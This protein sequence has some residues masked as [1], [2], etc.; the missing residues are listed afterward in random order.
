MVNH[1]LFN[2]GETII[3][4]GISDLLTPLNHNEFCNLFLRHAQGDWGIICEEDKPL[5]NEA[6]TSG[7]RI[8]SAYLFDGVKIW[9][10]TEAG[11]HC[12]TALLPDEY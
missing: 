6:I 5:N 12:T 8:M 1:N 9:I 2:L 10:I 7:D 4:Q 11:R 3:T